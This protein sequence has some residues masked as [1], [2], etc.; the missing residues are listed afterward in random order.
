MITKILYSYFRV[1]YIYRKKK[2]NNIWGT[3]VFRLKTIN[4]QS[5]PSYIYNTS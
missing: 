4:T 1:K 3:L 2:N 5:P